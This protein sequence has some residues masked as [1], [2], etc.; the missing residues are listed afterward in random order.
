MANNFITNNK[1]QKNTPSTMRKWTLRNF[2]ISLGFF[3]K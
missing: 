1:E 3:L 2:T